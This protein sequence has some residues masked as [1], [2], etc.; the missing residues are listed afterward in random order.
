MNHLHAYK[1]RPIFKC[2][3]N[4]A[5]KLIGKIKIKIKLTLHTSKRSVM[6]IFCVK[7]PFVFP[8]NV[9]SLG[10]SPSNTACLI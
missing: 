8:V 3:I 10:S 5:I 1:V 7:I 4:A 6:Y 9:N 2:F